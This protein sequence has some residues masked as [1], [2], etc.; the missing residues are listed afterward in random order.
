MKR[1]QQRNALWGL[2]L[3]EAAALLACRSAQAAEWSAEPYVLLNT[4]YT[5][6][7][8][9]QTTPRVSLWGVQGGPG[10]RLNGEAENW[11]VTGEGNFKIDRY[12]KSEFNTTEGAAS[13]RSDYRSE[14]NTYGL[15]FQF[16]R[17][18]T[19]LSELSNTG[20]VQAYT[21]RTQVTAN[22]TWTR[23]LSE[24]TNL[25]ASYN[26]TA[27]NYADTEG[28]SL[29]DYHDQ[30]VKAG[31]QHKLSE[32]TT[33]TVNGYYDFFETNPSTYRASIVGLQAGIAQDLSETLRA[34]IV[35][36][37]R[38][39]HSDTSAQAAVCTNV[40]VNGVCQGGVSTLGSDVTANSAGFTLIA[41]VMK[42]WGERGSFE[43]KAG[44]E[45]VPSGV[46]ALVQTDVL[47]L[48]LSHDVSERITAM[49]ETSF[50]RSRYVA[51]TLDPNKARY[52]RVE[53]HVN[54]RVA[55]N[56]LVD[57][58]YIYARQKFDLDAQ[59]AIANTVYVTLSYTWQKLAVSR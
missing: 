32:R 23:A 1:A 45:L 4:L 36:G 37:P 35:G 27:V 33:L 41:D 55:P 7:F 3:L 24:S 30:I 34:S 10:L 11:K 49:L 9:L 25:V 58:G 21:P 17:D 38:F 20:I 57:V 12:T 15:N 8:T 29:I 56:W 6:N 50:Y 39:T 16:I 51:S 40:I 14:R 13:L 2:A 59:S 48:V 43:V 31:I 26:F 18:N 53:P 54:W 19:L 44:R 5:D 46:A 42:R 52:F 47:R 28:T 22:P